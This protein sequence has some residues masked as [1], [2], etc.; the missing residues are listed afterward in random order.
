MTPLIGGHSETEKLSI[1]YGRFMC[2]I[3][4]ILFFL[5]LQLWL[6]ISQNTFQQNLRG[7]VNIP[8]GLDFFIDFLKFV[9]KVATTT[10]GS[11]IRL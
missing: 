11:H 2:A 7:R 3:D 1:L 8:I 5:N 4:K 6:V 9:F 10:T